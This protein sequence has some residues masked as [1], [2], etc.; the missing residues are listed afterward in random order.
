MYSNGGYVILQQAL[1]DIAQQPFPQII[2]EAVI[3]PLEMTHTRPLYSHSR[4]RAQQALALGMIWMAMLCPANTITFLNWRR[5]V[6]GQRHWCPY[7]YF[8]P[9]TQKLTCIVVRHQ[10][11]K[12]SYY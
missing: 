8:S 10:S 7:C 12:N 11:L 5:Q 4:K 9:R 3:E 2:D 1:I 6:F